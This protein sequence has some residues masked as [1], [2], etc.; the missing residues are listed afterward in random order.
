MFPK[1]ICNIATLCDDLCN[2][3]DVWCI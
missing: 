1:N 3:Q 2:L